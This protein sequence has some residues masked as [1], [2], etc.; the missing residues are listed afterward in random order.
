MTSRSRPTFEG[1]LPNI[2]LWVN[3]CDVVEI[4]FDPNTDG[5]VRAIDAT[6]ARLSQPVFE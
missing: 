4:G 3:D 5:F 6:S 1:A 2:T